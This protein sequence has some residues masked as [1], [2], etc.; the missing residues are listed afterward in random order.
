MDLFPDYLTTLPLDVRQK[1]SG[2]ISQ[3]IIGCD[4]NL[5]RTKTPSDEQVIKALRIL[6]ARLRPEEAVH[7]LDSRIHVPFLSVPDMGLVSSGSRISDSFL[8]TKKMIFL[9]LNFSEGHFEMVADSPAYLQMMTLF[10]CESS[11]MILDYPF[12]FV[13]LKS[14]AFPTKSALRLMTF[15]AFEISRPEIIFRNSLLHAVLSILPQCA[16]KLSD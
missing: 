4:L 9:K 5:H 2:S 14:L 1:I 6:F 12:D 15:S 13:V 10:N 3:S 7:S 8:P 11:D 16:A